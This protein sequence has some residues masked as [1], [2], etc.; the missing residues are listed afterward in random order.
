MKE[1]HESQRIC[2]FLL[3]KEIQRSF[4]KYNLVHSNCQVCNKHTPKRP[5]IK[6]KAWNYCTPFVARPASPISMLL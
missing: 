1:K 6:N 4:R 2:L 5:V 3:T